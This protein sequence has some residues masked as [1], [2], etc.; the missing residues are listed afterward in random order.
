MA[1]PLSPH[2]GRWASRRT[3]PAAARAFTLLELLAVV[4][5]VGVL[6]AVFFGAAHGAR[7]RSRRAQAAAELAVLAQALE[8]YRNEQGDY[9][10]TGMA[11]NVP[12]AP[13]AADDGPGILLNALLGRRGPDAVLVPRTGRSYVILGAHALQHPDRGE[14]AA[15]QLANAFLDP[16]G[17]RYL[18]WYRTGAAWTRR[19]PV[20]LCVGAD[21]ATVAPPAPATWDGVASTTGP[22]ADDL[23][24]FTSRP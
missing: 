21:G 7:E 4:A 2:N 10:R 22:A 20:L 3:R 9:P 19:A 24:A 6:T 1:R 18:Y 5:I 14:A 8:A 17:R 16:W 13:P 12:D 11:G 23:H 15:G